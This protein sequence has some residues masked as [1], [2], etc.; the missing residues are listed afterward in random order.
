MNNVDIPSIQHDTLQSDHPA[1][2]ARAYT[3]PPRPVQPLDSYAR[4]L[5]DAEKGAIGAPGDTEKVLTDGA[6]TDEPR[7]SSPSAIPEEE[8]G[9]ESEAGGPAAHTARGESAPVPGTTAMNPELRQRR[10]KA[11]RAQTAP[12]TA[13]RRTS[14]D[15]EED[16]SAGLVRKGTQVL[17]GLLEP[18]IPVAKPPGWRSSAMNIVKHSWLNVLLVFVPVSWACSLSNQSDVV[19]FVMSFVAII[20]LAGLLSF[21]TEDL[22]LRV[23]ETLG[24]LLNASFGNAVELLIAILALVKG[25]LDVVQSSMVGSLLS[26]CLLVLGMCYFA[27]GLRFH[28]QVYS[29]RPAQVNINM[30]VLSVVAF[31]VPV[32]FHSFVEDEGNET[33]DVTD[34]KVLKIS[35]GVAIILL[36]SYLAY[37]AFTLWTH[38]YIY[39]PAPR[40]NPNEDPPMAPMAPANY[41]GE[42]NPPLPEGAVFRIPSLPSWG[43]SSDGSSD[44]SSTSS[45][46]SSED[47]LLEHTPKMSGRVAILLLVVST[48]LTGVTAE[49]LVSSI[50]GLVES[51][52]VS[53]QFVA[54]ILLPLAGNAA[55]HATAV[56][57]ATKNKLD[58][59]MAVAIGSSIQIA[60]FVV[61]VL[62]LLGWCIGQPLT[63][64]F[65]EFETV[66]LFIS[67][68]AVA[69]ATSDGRTNWLEGFGLMVIYLIVAVVIY[70]Y[71]PTGSSVS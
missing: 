65:D 13:V 19:T 43:S 8:G 39:A 64:Y 17:A 36:F 42:V 47:S 53:E 12:A 62:I 55:E 56:T 58:L 3:L 59:S 45:S 22:A 69:F 35:H 26:N 67:I 63:F 15:Q 31:V 32:A 20:P 28:E 10:P 29:V 46:S 25:E 21:A 14:Q 49:W 7:S 40:P 50:E 68:V 51:G 38:A 2:P 48:A 54:F 71:D 33:L 44:T 37:L 18:K 6:I 70:Y 9:A 66:I 11:A 52:G 57:V 34:N 61:P 5:S 1:P 60:L 41:P 27:G 24:G 16:P 30:L 4:S 23:G